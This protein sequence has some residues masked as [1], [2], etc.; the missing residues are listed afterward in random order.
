[1]VDGLER[2]LAG[3][4]RV[5]RLNVAD[6]IGEQARDRY[7]V[8]KVPSLLQVDR[9]GVESYR[10]EGKLPRKQQVTEALG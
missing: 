10:S 2:E 6:A 8:E 7:G 5:I 3:R 4:A 9:S 1:M